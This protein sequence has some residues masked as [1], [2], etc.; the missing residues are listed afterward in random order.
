MWKIIKKEI[1]KNNCQNDI[2]SLKINNSI[3][4]NPQE[5]ANTSNNYFLTVAD[6]VLYLLYFPEIHIQE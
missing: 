5:I 6:P 4:N 1:G 3:T 2:H